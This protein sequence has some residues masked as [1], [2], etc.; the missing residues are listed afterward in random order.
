MGEYIT[1]LVLYFIDLFIFN[2]L[3]HPKILDQ[4]Q[5]QQL[6]RTLIWR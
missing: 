3:F 2:G 1:T 6:Y 4:C 5:A